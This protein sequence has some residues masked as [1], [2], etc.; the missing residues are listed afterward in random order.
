[1][2]TAADVFQA[3]MAKLFECPMEID[4]DDVYKTLFPEILK[5]VMLQA[6]DVEN[7]YRRAMHMPYVSIDICASRFPADSTTPLPFRD[8]MAAVVFPLYIAS[9]FLRD[10][11]QQDVSAY[12]RE[13]Y[14][15]ALNEMDVCCETEV[16][17][18]L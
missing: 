9:E 17:C 11:Q 5:S 13:Q 14:V 18:C 8:K 15:S 6:R 2:Q 10:S 7:N 16:D 3:S 1:M 4:T 12:L